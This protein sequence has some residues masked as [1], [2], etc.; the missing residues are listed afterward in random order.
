MEHAEEHGHIIPYRTLVKVWLLLL[1]LTATLVFV[2]TAYHDLLSVPALLTIT[3]LKAALVFFYFMHLKYE[4]PFFRGMVLLV[5]V[6]LIVFIGLTFA[7]I[8]YR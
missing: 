5:L 8:S 6:V 2:S 1:F 7:D 4:K 3:P